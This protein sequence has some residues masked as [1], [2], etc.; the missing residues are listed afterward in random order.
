MEALNTLGTFLGGAWASGINLY[1]TIAALGIAD[2]IGFIRLPD[3]ID[4]LSHPLVITVALV[5]FSVE[6]F[7]DKIPYV[8]SAWDS[9]HT[10]VRPAGAALLAFMGT[11]ETAPPVQFSI[12]LL[13][14]AV[15]LD[16][17]LT[18]AST[19]VAINAS[20]EP[21]TNIIASFSED[22]LVFAMLFL[23]LKHPVIAGI[24]VLCFVIFSLWFL[25]MMFRFVRKIFNFAFSKKEQ[26]NE[27]ST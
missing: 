13:C 15:A 12:T 4:V 17:H 14:A 16:S 8:D 22:V 2:R 27:S 21:F 25:T 10:F 3:S 11:S 9:I 1:L 20:P 26:L 6:F 24:I 23:V 18:K 7:A 19:R 5:L